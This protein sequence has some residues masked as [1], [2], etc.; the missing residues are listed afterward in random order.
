[1]LS[2]VILSWVTFGYGAAFICFIL[3]W[4]LKNKAA[5]KLGDIVVVISFIAHAG[6]VVL[7]WVESYRMGIGHVPLTIFYESLIFLS[8]VI[9]VIYLVLR[10]AFRYT[11]LGVF[12]I[13]FSLLTL[14]YASLSPD[15]DRSIRPLVPALQSNWLTVHV[16]T[17]FLSYAA[18]A[19]SFVVALLY[20][21]RKDGKPSVLPDR[22]TLDELTYRGVLAGM[23][24]LTIGIITGA[25]W[26]HFAWGS[27]WSW[28]PKETWSLITW[29]IYALFLHAR[30]IR[31]WKGTRSAVLSVIGFLCVIFTF[32]GVNFVLSGLHSYM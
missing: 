7:R 32:L 5:N 4:M 27:Y 23:P 22:D 13:P 29:I 8:L 2:S 6:A 15:V 1:M 24:L 16:M 28:D 9:T 21:F 12:M 30:L 11:F 10:F 25:F 18:F 20:L 31:G 3:Q 26:A 19:F 14:A 17:C